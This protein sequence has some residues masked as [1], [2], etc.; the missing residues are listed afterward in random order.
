MFVNEFG[1]TITSVTV[2]TKRAAPVANAGLDLQVSLTCSGEGRR[3]S[4][5]LRQT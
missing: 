5:N 1:C 3:G 4:Q 2:I